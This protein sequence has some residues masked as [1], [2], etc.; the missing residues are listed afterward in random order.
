MKKSSINKSYK[1]SIVVVVL[2]FFAVGMLLSGVATKENSA[3]LVGLPLLVSPIFSLLGL[4]YWFG[5]MQE[6]KN[7][8]KIISILVHIVSILFFMLLLMSNLMDLNN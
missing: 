3:L 2:F 1:A 8:K 7:F 6:P 5:G 4:Y